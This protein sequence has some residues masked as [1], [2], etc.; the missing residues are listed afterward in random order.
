VHL[1]SFLGAS[2][3]LGMMSPAHVAA[4]AAQ[5]AADERASSADMLDWGNASVLAGATG[6]GTSARASDSDSES[7]RGS[8]DPFADFFGTGG[9]QA[10]AVGLQVVGGL[11]GPCALVLVLVL[12][13]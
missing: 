10:S 8:K 12:V 2:D 11:R 1:G 13:V 5:Q 9:W 7:V 4:V 3:A 6:S